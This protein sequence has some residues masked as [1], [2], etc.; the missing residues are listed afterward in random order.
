MV[1]M[2]TNRNESCF[3]EIGIPTYND[4]N[5]TRK[6]DRLLSI[7]ELETATLSANVKILKGSP[8]TLSF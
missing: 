7:L 1:R 6:L 3:L 5:R 8:G 2:V 4:Y